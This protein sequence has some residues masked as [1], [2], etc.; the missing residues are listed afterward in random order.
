MSSL[1][2]LAIILSISLVS[3][4]VIYLV[5]GTQG[6]MRRGFGARHIKIAAGGLAAILVIASAFAGWYFIAS[7]QRAGAA[8]GETAL[9]GQSPV[10]AASPATNGGDLNVLVSRLEDRL[11]REPGDAQGLALYARTLM[12]LKRYSDAAS[13]YAKAVDA[14]P[15]DAALHL[16]RA[17]AAF[18]ASGEKWT[19]VAREALARG[20]ALSPA[21][22]EALWLAGR[23]R[24]ESKDYPAAVRYWEALAKVAP[25]GSDYEK[26]MKTALVEARALRDGR[27]P[28]TE[29]A[30]AGVSAPP[31]ESAVGK[32]PANPANAGLAAELRNTLS[33]MDARTAIGPGAAGPA[34]VRGTVSLEPALRPGTRPEDIVFVFARHA[35]PAMG[36]APLA[37]LRKRVADLPLQ[38]ELSDNNAMSSEQKLSNARS[39]IITARISKS[40]DAAYQ[41]GDL[42]SVSPAVTPRTGGLILNISGSR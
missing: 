38:F 2:A 7:A 23:E 35:D 16:E 32:S 39:V 17:D 14:I 12:E 41:P 15:D 11:R 42:E 21:H 30:R 22:P 4:V 10:Q 13:A 19:P 8:S 9:P 24:F 26:E 29:L 18:M 37:M 25:S 34:F 28:A 27:D 5:G 20:L 33:A 6:G 3:V 31:L 40:G 36:P 1:V